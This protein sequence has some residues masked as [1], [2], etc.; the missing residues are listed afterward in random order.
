MF[1]A[2]QQMVAAAVGLQ[3]RGWA[4]FASTFAAFISR[5]YDFIR[6]AA[7][8]Q[9][10][11]CLCGSHAGVS[12]GEDGPSQMAL[13][14]IAAFRAVNGSTVLH[15]SDANQTAQLVG[16]L[17]DHPGISYL[18]TLRSA[19]LVRT[20]ADEAIRIGGS[21][22]VRTSREDRFTIVACGITVEEAERAADA[23]EADGIRVR[24]IDC[25]SIKPID[26]ATLE[27]AASETGGFVTVEDHWPAGGLGEAVLS[28]LA[29]G[30]QVRPLI[31][32]AVGGMPGSGK[33]DE[34]RHAA[35]IDAEAIVRAVH[36][37]AGDA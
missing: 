1:I 30:G 2:E 17:A 4:P 6:M 3:T 34:L 27:A 15:P 21:R 9:A 24:V 28:A 23:L 25:Y 26:A 32:L 22:F 33:P 13:E 8:S 20:A 19:T 16:V 11:I 29:E 5:A 31:K 14:D 36:R 37:L 7:I 35:G 10:N 18:R 12:I